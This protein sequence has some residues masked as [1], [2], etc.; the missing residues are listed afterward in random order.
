MSHPGYGNKRAR[1]ECGPVCGRKSVQMLKWLGI[2]ERRL[3]RLVMRHRY[4]WYRPGSVPGT[5]RTTRL[6]TWPSYPMPLSFFARPPI[7]HRSRSRARKHADIWKLG[8]RS[9]FTSES[10]GTFPCPAKPGSVSS[11]MNITS[12]ASLPSGATP[13]RSGNR[14]SASAIT[15]STGRPCNPITSNAASFPVMLPGL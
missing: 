11:F 7:R 13:G 2:Q 12:A 5:V 6:G 14:T 4:I 9:G 15:S 10:P 1:A 8:T 3:S